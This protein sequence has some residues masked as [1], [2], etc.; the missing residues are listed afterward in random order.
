MMRL[1]LSGPMTGYPYFNSEAFDSA[2]EE[3]REAGYE[4]FNPVEH[5][6]EMGFDPMLHPKGK[7][8]PEF[9][10]REALKAD[11]TWILDHAEGVATLPGCEDSKG[12]RAEIALAEALGLSV[13]SAQGWILYAEWGLVKAAG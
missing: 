4:V 1:Y 7:V 8:T 9:P 13:V 2:A 5:D 12:A 11:L 6:R 10:L 3:L